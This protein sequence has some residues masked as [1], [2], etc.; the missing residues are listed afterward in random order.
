[1]KLFNESSG[2]SSQERFVVRTE[3]VGALCLAREYAN[4][5]ALEDFCRTVPEL[6]LEFP[7]RPQ[8]SRRLQ[9]LVL[10]GSPR[11]GYSLGFRLGLDHYQFLADVISLSER[12][13]DQVSLSSGDRDLYY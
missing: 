2:F 13:L 11:Y 5:S 4:F 9:E 12:K 6:V 3:N 7:E 8:Q 10:V 1:M